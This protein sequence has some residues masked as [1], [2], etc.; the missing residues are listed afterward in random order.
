MVLRPAQGVQG[1]RDRVRRGAAAARRGVGA[2]LGYRRRRLS[3]VHLPPARMGDRP[4]GSL[5]RRARTPQEQL[6]SATVPTATL[7]ETAALL[8]QAP[9]SAAGPVPDDETPDRLP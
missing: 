3:V 8:G 1:A 5:R 6:M 7:P 2:V 9:P 4:G